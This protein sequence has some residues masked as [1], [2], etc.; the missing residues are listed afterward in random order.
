MKSSR[1]KHVIQ[2]GSKALIWRDVGNIM[3]V[4]T[5]E[6]RSKYYVDPYKNT[7]KRAFEPI[8]IATSAVGCDALG[9]A[10]KAMA[11]EIRKQ[12]AEEQE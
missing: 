3:L 10:L 1:N 12:K 5:T 8:V 2:V 6:V 4:D 11:A 9:D 7:G